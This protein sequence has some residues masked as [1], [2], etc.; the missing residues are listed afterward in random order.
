M[1]STPDTLVSVVVPCLNRAGFLRPT[2]D[3]ILNQDY[4][5]V[6]CIVMD[7]GSKDD[8]LEVLES[9]STRI[10]WVSEPDRGQADA[11]NKGWAMSRGSVLTWLNADDVWEVPHTITRVVEFLD[12][13]PDVDV[14]YGQCGRIDL[15]GNLIG[16]SYWRDW[17]LDHAVEFCDHCIA[18]PASFIRRSAIDRVGKL[19]ISFRQKM[20]HELWLRIGLEGKIRHLPTL[21]A[22][23]RFH[24]GVSFERSA[25]ATCVQV[26]R[27]FYSFPNVPGHL[28][29]R[30]SRALS[31]SYVRGI[32][33]EWAGA[34]RWSL[35]LWYAT[36][37]V[38][39]DPSNLR[40]AVRAIR[41]RAW[42]EMHKRLPL[43]MAWLA[44]SMALL[45]FK[46]F[47]WIGSS[48]RFL[49]S[50]I[51]PLPRN[52]SG[53]RDVEWSWVAANLPPGEGSALDFGCGTGAL[54]LLAAQAGFDVLAIDLQRVSWRYF[55]PRLRFL[56]TDLLGFELPVSHYQLVI[57][58][59]AVEHVGLVGRYGVVE[60]C[61]DGDLEAMA[62]LFECMAPGGV[63]LL[64]VPVG[65]DAVFEPLTRVYGEE[66]LPKLLAG[67]AVLR[68]DF[69]VKN[70][71]NR[72]VQCGRSEALKFEAAAGSPEPARNVYAL[73][74]MVLKKPHDGEVGILDA[75]DGSTID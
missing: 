30:R 20:D 32:D 56:R 60:E 69:W 25:P 73:G 44:A 4:Q 19:D 71:D 31:N 62:R 17:N 47:R 74:C 7:G 46:M 24:P 37:A 13:N 45:P 67:F 42:Q 2:V 40:A 63:M 61:P 34:K 33:Y 75:T 14:A 23:A 51:A 68:E 39:C 58:C 12:S 55:H 66:R 65:E 57:N 28:R 18:Q 8:T 59:S 43:R 50:P 6:E 64:T 26:T 9:Y 22:H 35:V 48:V 16:M 70:E 53:D 36:L 41:Q 29:A 72:W 11:I 5:H 38:G 52:L 54:G 27:K 10:T 3:S 1:T 49:F 21:L 15:D